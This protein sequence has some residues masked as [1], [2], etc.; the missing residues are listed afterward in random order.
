M[1]FTGVSMEVHRP[2]N[3]LSNSPVRDEIKRP[4]EAVQATQKNSGQAE[5]L[6]L[7]SLQNTN[8]PDCF[9]LAAVLQS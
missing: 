9:T 7:L 5:K 4:A 6:R 2:W 8:S 3:K 1:W